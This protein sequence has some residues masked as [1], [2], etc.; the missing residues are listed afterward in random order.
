MTPKA[1]KIPFRLGTRQRMQQF[2][3]VAIALGN[4]VTTELPRVGFLAGILLNVRATVTLSAG[5]ALA[6]GAPW[7]LLKRVKVSLNTGAASIFDCSGVG[8][9]LVN[10]RMLRSA[11]DPTNSGLVSAPVANG[12]N[13]WG[14]NLYIPISI[15]DE[16]QFGLGLINLQAPEVRCTIDITFATTGTDLSTNF[17]TVTGNVDMSYVYYEVPDP[18]RVAFPPLV[19]HRILE[20]RQAITAV[21]DQVY[22]FPRGG[23]VLQLLHLVT[24]NG[25]Y[26]TPQAAGAGTGVG[27]VDG[28]RLILNKTDTL[29]NLPYRAWALWQ[30]LNKGMGAQIGGA[31]TNAGIAW[32]HNFLDASIGRIGEGDFRDT[33]DSESIST[34]ESIVTVNSAAVLGAANYLDSIRRI[35]QPLQA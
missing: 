29:Y 4:Q 26:A 20:E 6:L 2:A 22:T 33:I 21:G 18:R 32:E 8:L 24:I 31:L 34:L 25:H 3:T 12:A 1:Q 17:S 10:D 13:V 23:T 16:L 30:A 27:E 19:L 35:F 11:Y 14:F 7:N 9:Y 5:G 15:N 28:M